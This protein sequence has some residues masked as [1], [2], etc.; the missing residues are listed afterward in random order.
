MQMPFN[1]VPSMF[2]G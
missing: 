1:A 2:D